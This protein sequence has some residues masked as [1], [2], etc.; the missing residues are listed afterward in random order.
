M[1]WLDGIINSMDMYLSKLQETMKDR[2]AWCATVHEIT[3]IWTYLATGQEE[4]L[5]LEKNLIYLQALW[6]TV[7][8]I[9]YQV[10]Q[11]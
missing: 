7:K 2:E 8:K 1:I 11:K 4:A 9:L 5:I 3:K 6:R 10:K